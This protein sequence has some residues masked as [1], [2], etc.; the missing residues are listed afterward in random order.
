[1]ASPRFQVIQQADDSFNVNLTTADG[2]L[3]TITGFS[4][5]HE[6]TAW[7]AQT[8]RLLQQRDPLLVLPSRNKS[9]S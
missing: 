2:R 1:M 7:G 9:H 8:V 4:G 6:A 5:E 3:K